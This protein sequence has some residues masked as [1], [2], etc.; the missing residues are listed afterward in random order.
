[1][2]ADIVSKNGNLMLNIPV[3]GDG[4]ID[5]KER[6]I[7]E[8]IGEWMKAN[9]ESIYGTRPW[10]VF[11]EG[12]AIE[13]A[14]PLAAQGFNEGKGAA[15]TARDWRFAVKGEVL[16]ATCFDWPEG[17]VATVRSLAAGGALYPAEI[18][19]VKMVATGEPLTFRRTAEGLEVNFPEKR[20][21]AAY[22]NVISV[23]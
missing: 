21:G 1:M 4:T 16:Y 22:A 9:G 5:E 3:R 14:A 7:V 11:G 20:A 10:K 15:L 19:T 2:L 17:G 12:P 8:E 18:R 13:H 6:A 23:S